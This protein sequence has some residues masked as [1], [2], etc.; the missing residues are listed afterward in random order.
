MWCEVWPQ[1]TKQETA[2]ISDENYSKMSL[3]FVD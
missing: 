3:V 2:N 1:N